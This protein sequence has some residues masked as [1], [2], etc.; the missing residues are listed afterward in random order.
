MLMGILKNVMLAYHIT[1]C[2]SHFFMLCK[3]F[4]KYIRKNHMGFYMFGNPLYFDHVAH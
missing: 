2:P 3:V 1:K 4:F